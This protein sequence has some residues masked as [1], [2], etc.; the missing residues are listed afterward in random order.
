MHYGIVSTEAGTQ[1]MHCLQI[2][3]SPSS[4]WMAESLPLHCGSF[5]GSSWTRLQKCAWMVAL[6]SQP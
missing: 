1:E 4:Q 2:L 3:M 6:G 5:S